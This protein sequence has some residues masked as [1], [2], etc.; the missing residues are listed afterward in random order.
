[1]SDKEAKQIKIF[2]DI[3][4]ESDKI[5]EDINKGIIDAVNED[6]NITGFLEKE[7]KKVDNFF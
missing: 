3:I 6:E 1:M 2:S 7:Q 5:A 4:E